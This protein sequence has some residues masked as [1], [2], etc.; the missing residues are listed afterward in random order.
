M[1]ECE[2]TSTERHDTSPEVT[3]VER[4]VD[5]SERNSGETAL[6]GDVTL[7]SLLLL[8]LGE[9]GINDLAEHLLHLL[10]GELLGQL[11]YTGQ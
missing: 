8:S 9:A 11:K 4:H 7:S 10:N 5:T 1:K 3:G 6:K 2:R